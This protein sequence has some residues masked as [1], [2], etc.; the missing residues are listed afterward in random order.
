MEGN[1]NPSIFRLYE[2]KKLKTTHQIEIPS[3]V[4]TL[5]IP[6]E[7]IMEILARLP[8][9]SLLKF[10]CVCKFWL[11]LIS[12]SQFIKIH[13]KNS[14]DNLILSNHMLLLTICNRNFDL[15]HCSVKSL[16]FEPHT[17]AYT[18]DYPM[19]NHHSAVWVVGSCNGLVCVA[20]DEDDI[21][22]WNPAT[23]LSKKLPPVSVQLRQGFYYIWG[24]GYDESDDDYK[25]VGVFCVFRDGSHYDS[26]VKIYSLR[27]DS[28]KIIESFKGGVPLHDSGKFA[29]GKLHFPATHEFSDWNIVSLD[30]NSEDY[31]TVEQPNYGEVFFDASLGVLRGCL[32]VICNYENV[33]S[34]VWVLKEY[35]IKESWT[36]LVT[37]PYF[38]EAGKSF[39]LSPLCMLP[40]GEILLAVGTGLVV[41]DPRASCFRYLETSNISAFLEA[42]IYFESLVSFQMQGRG[43]NN[44]V[45]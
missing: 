30:L 36:K 21:F 17:V 2:S 10:R 41:Y 25:V 24:F 7:I 3:N 34:D 28:W 39:F 33:R 19:K 42:D 44:L 27:T 43:D 37:I 1:G 22:L 9:K 4:D 8:V 35:G 38:G 40:N 12:S 11:S 29:S 18:I 13:L 20:I 6:P 26:V 31:G 16:M 15:R 45:H 23:R 5:N 32:C 14:T